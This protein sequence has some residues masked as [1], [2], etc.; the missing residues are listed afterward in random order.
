MHRLRRAA[1]N[2]KKGVVRFEARLAIEARM[3][4]NLG[5]QQTHPEHHVF[6]ES[7]HDMPLITIIFL[8][9]APGL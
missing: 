7:A 6:S 1:Q 3:G 8:V 9:Y 5:N 2:I 4:R